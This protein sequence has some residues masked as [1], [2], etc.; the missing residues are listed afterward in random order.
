[1]KTYSDMFN[2]WDFALH[3]IFDKWF[4]FVVFPTCPCS[5]LNFHRNLKF[6]EFQFPRKSAEIWKSIFIN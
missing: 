5:F 3:V 6:Y 1:M 2:A 4:I